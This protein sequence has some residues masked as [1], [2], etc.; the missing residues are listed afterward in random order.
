M[1]KLVL[2]ERSAAGVNDRAA[3]RTR[4]GRITGMAAVLAT[5]LLSLTGCG[6]DGFLRFTGKT[7]SGIRVPIDPLDAR[8]LGFSAQWPKMLPLGRGETIEHAVLAGD[9]VLTVERP[10]NLLT[11]ISFR[12][13]STV[14]RK[15]VGT[16]LEILYPPMRLTRGV[17]D[18]DRVLI[19]SNRR[20]FSYRA[21][22]GAL[23]YVTNLDYPVSHAPAIYNDFAIFGGG[24]GRVF[25][26]SLISGFAHWEYQLPAEVRI[27]PA[28]SGSMVFAV[29]ASGIYVMLDA[30]TGD[31]LWKGR[32]FAP[33]D[34]APAVASAIYL[35]S[36]DQTLYALDRR[37]GSDR[38]KY[39]DVQPLRESPVV[40]GE[41]VIQP[42]TGRGIVAIH[43]GEGHEVWRLPE[44][45]QVVHLY[46]DQ[47]LLNM[48]NA[49]RMV[50]AATGETLK[51]VPTRPLKTVLV[52]RET[53]NLVLVT[54]DGQMQ[55]LDRM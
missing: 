23:L 52:D 25:A 10:H 50:D 31:V 40:V 1:N 29:D 16:E 48:G 32:T 46:G 9:L 6:T 53:G 2:A 11:A 36:R 44:R 42:L 3:A 24:N 12:D 26:H 4:P 18:D 38:W 33:V 55:R 51:Q 34:A 5:L 37:D 39:R 20:M 8:A 13:G 21:M 35:A 28:L 7:E 45:A 49:L 43:A 14:W 54:V 47:L 30:A 15:P 41:Y 27:A 17:A 22:D 19:N